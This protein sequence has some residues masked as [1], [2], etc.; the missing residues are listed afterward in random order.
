MLARGS[1]GEDCYREEICKVS[2]RPDMTF[3]CRGAAEAGQ[4]SDFAQRVSKL[5]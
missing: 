2:A 3:V 4:F 5:L 1:R